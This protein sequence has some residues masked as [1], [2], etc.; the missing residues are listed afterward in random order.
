[1]ITYFDIIIENHQS[2][3][4][5]NIGLCYYRVGD[6]PFLRHL[7]FTKNNKIIDPTLFT[8]VRN[9]SY[10]SNVE[11]IL[12]KVLSIKEYLDICFSQKTTDIRGSDEERYFFD[13]VKKD[14]LNIIDR[15]YFE[16]ID[17]GE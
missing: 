3:M 5:F 13:R 15:D 7:V 6:I 8:H 4:G 16:F 1:M 11:Y 17:R 2:V 9:I 14:K 12:V 10:L